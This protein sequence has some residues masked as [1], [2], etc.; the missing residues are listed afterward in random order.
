MQMDKWRGWGS[1]VGADW[2]GWGVGGLSLLWSVLVKMKADSQRWP[3]AR[4]ERERSEQK[5]QDSSAVLCGA[6]AVVSYV[7]TAECFACGEPA[8]QHDIFHPAISPSLSPLSYL[9]M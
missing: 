1:V 8:S 3:R 5:C 7:G 4:A 9:S 6:A 2:R